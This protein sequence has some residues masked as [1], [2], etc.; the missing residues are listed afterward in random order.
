MVKGKSRF[1]TEIFALWSWKIVK[2]TERFFPCEL[3]RLINAE[4]SRFPRMSGL[5]MEILS[6]DLGNAP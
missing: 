1:G 6:V 2:K 5:I 4:E 3:S